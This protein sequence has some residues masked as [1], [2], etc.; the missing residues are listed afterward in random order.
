MNSSSDGFL[1]NTLNEIMRR[2]LGERE[3]GE[4]EYFRQEGP[5]QRPGVWSSAFLTWEDRLQGEPRVQ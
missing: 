5:V 3:E 4:V 2:S 1:L